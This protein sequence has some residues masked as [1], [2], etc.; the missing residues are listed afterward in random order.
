MPRSPI[1]RLALLFCLCGVLGLGGYAA[2]L[3]GSGAGPQAI[4][5]LNDVLT[6]RFGDDAVR[7]SMTLVLLTCVFGVLALAWGS[8]HIL[9]DLG[10]EAE[11]G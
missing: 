10:E 11:P 6:P 7:Y 3:Y 8:T 4:G 5:I 1:A 9:R 2:W